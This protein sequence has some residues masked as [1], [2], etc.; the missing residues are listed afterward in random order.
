MRERRFALDR[1]KVLLASAISRKQGGLAPVSRAMLEDLGVL[2]PNAIAIYK[3][4]TGLCAAA[5]SK[6][7]K[8]FFV[9]ANTPRLPLRLPQMLSAVA[10]LL[11]SKFSQFARRLDFADGDASMEELTRQSSTKSE[12]KAIGRQL[13]EVAG[14]A[15]E[16][17]AATAAELD[18]TKAQL[19]TEV[20]LF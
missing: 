17:R 3:W 6:T 9:R 19:A 5:F 2:G 16:G 8:P 15:E 12:L 1:T 18:K 4:R 10:K 11:L 14:Q 7:P 20:C 13:Q